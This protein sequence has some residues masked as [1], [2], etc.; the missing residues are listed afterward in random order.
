MARSASLQ[1]VLK[2]KDLSFASLSKEGVPVQHRDVVVNRLRH[3]DLAVPTLK[4][5]KKGSKHPKTDGEVAKRNSDEPSC[6]GNL[7]VDLLG[8]LEGFEGPSLR[9]ISTDHEVLR[10]LPKPNASESAFPRP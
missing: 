5:S 10:D 3:S 2:P 8:V 4:T 9:A 1:A 6:H 7:M